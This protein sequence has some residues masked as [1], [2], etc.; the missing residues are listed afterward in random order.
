MRLDFLSAI[1]SVATRGE[2]SLSAAQ[3]VAY[4]AQLR[5]TMIVQGQTD[6]TNVGHGQ[7]RYR[8]GLGVEALFVDEP[9]GLHVEH[10]EVAPRR[11]TPSLALTV[12]SQVTPSRVDPQVLDVKP[13][14]N[15]QRPT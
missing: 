6:V 4:E 15:P 13:G 8:S 3:P 5:Q 9:P 10:G 12:H 7:G 14:E 11:V 2:G 1:R